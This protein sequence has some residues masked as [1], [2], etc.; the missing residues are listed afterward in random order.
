MRRVWALPYDTGKVPNDRWNA[1]FLVAQQWREG[2]QI[3][4]DKLRFHNI[5]IQLNSMGRA[6]EFRIAQIAELLNALNKGEKISF[7]R[8]I[9]IPVI[10][11]VIL[12]FAF[13]KD[14]LSKFNGVDQLRVS[15]WTFI[16][17][18]VSQG[19]FFVLCSIFNLRI[20]LL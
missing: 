11:R 19:I 10:E 6:L 20:K 15:T 7:T 1:Y 2:K 8:R 14:A 17:I 3:S 5:L 12:K 9:D 13:A 16:I 18:F 4:A